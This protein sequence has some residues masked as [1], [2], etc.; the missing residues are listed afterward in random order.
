MNGCTANNH[1]AEEKIPTCIEEKIEALKEEAVRNPPA[2][3]ARYQF[4]GRTVYYIPPAAGD[5]MSK[6]YGAD[7]ELI[8]RPDGGFTGR[9]DG[10]CPEFVEERKEEEIIWRDDRK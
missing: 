2:Y 9:G 1:F 6:L 5:Q 7:C 4:K 8:C 3:I 10:E